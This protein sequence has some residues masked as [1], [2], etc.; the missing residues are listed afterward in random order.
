ML[1]LNADDN[2]NPLVAKHPPI[3]VVLRKPILSIK[4]PDTGDNRNVVPIVSDP[5][6]AENIYNEMKK[7]Y[8]L[9]IILFDKG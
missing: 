5:T 3:N 4:I 7:N 1:E 9:L 8:Y 2:N 6:S